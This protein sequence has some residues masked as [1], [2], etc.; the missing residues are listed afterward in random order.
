MSEL[1]KEKLAVRCDDL[2]SK[3]TNCPCRLYVMDKNN[4]KVFVSQLE[5]VIISIKN[6]NVDWIELNGSTC[7]RFVTILDGVLSVMSNNKP[8]LKEFVAHCS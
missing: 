1:E 7:N 6:W 5:Y 8:L 3:A 4:I 2:F